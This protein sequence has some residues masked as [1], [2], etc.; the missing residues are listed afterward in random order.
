M[1]GTQRYRCPV[2]HTLVKPGGAADWVALAREV[3]G[4]SPLEAMAVNLGTDQVSARRMLAAWARR[5]AERHLR[6]PPGLGQGWWWK[7]AG[8][9]TV[10]VGVMRGKL[11]RV[12]GWQGGPAPPSGKPLGKALTTGTQQWVQDILTGAAGDPAEEADRL[13]IAMARTNAW[14]LD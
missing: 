3:L 8:G 1:A 6:Q 2:C 10:G 13:W 4:G 5:S 9:Y 7:L 12:V 14:R 11:P